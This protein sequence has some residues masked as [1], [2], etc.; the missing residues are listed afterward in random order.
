[1]LPVF[2]WEKCSLYSWEGY[3]CCEKRIDK[4]VEEFNDAQDY[5]DSLVAVPTMVTGCRQENFR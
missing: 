1:M 4:F 2:L 3:I 5:I